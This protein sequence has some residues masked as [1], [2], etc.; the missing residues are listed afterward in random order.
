MR[1]GE[2]KE[3]CEEPYLEHQLRTAEKGKDWD[4]Y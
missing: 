2:G 3:Q 1:M 4:R